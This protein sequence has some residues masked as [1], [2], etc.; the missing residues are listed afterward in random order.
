MLTDVA[1]NPRVTEKSLWTSIACFPDTE[2]NGNDN[3]LCEEFSFC[4]YVCNATNRN[5][6]CLLYMHIYCKAIYY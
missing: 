5:S 1:V 6:N 4:V 2:A 3:N